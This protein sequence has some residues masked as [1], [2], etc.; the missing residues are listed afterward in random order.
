MFVVIFFF[1][2][3]QRTAYEVRLS[4]WSSD[5]FSS[6]LREGRV[7][8]VY[9]IPRSA[10]A[11]ARST[12]FRLACFRRRMPSGKHDYARIDNAGFDENQNRHARVSL[13][14]ALWSC[15]TKIE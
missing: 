15:P 6:D 8:I 5:V 14:H 4:D 1:C 2:V 10:A 9:G 13:K 12:R 3:T 11:H 7:N